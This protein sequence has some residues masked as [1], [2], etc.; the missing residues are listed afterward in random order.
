MKV[1]A[2]MIT[3][4]KVFVLCENGK[5]VC[6][7]EV[8]GIEEAKNFLTGDSFRQMA[9]HAAGSDYML[10][11][12]DDP[13]GD[14][15]ILEAC[16]KF[17]KIKKGEL[18]PDSGKVVQEELP[19]ETPVSDAETTPETTEEKPVV[20]PEKKL[21]KTPEVPTSEILEVKVT[22][23]PKEETLCNLVRDLEELKMELAGIQ[24]EYNKKIKDCMKQIFDYA[25]GE[26]RIHVE[27]EITYDWETGVR[28]WHR[29]DTGE[30]VKTE[31][32]PDKLRQVEM[33]LEISTPESVPEAVPETPIVTT[34]ICPSCKKFNPEVTC[35]VESVEVGEGD[36]IIKCSDFD[37]VV[38]DGEVE[39]IVEE[40]EPVEEH[41]PE[42]TE[43]DESTIVDDSHE[44]VEIVQPTDCG[45]YLQAG[46]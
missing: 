33:N 39:A 7:H 37:P 40:Q 21:V 20:E 27:C 2:Y 11:W 29:T 8:G 31:S 3:R 12:S 14:Q 17:E 22:P 4:T 10:I 45:E 35:Q 16:E 25:K 26:S 15:E 6:D 42:Q 44:S 46:V 19:I 36:V 43:V 23:T 18:D 5:L 38:P 13:A 9:D 30:H 41:E 24:A 1:F 32:I 34:A 28:Y